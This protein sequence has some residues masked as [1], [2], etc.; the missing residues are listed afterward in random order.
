MPPTRFHDARMDRQTDGWTD[1]PTRYP[2][3]QLLVWEEK[4][5]KGF[6]L[7]LPGQQEFFMEHNYLGEFERRP[8]K[9]HYCETW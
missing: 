6:L 2:I 7:W 4:I 9:E 3:I 8:P 1:R 5:F